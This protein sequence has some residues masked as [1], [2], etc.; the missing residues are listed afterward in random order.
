VIC[1]VKSGSSHQSFNSLN[2]PYYLPPAL[3]GWAKT[4]NSTTTTTTWRYP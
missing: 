4:R 1:A 2:H 3:S